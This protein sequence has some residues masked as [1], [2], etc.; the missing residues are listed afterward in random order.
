MPLKRTPICTR[1][2]S[3]VAGQ[4]GA[5]AARTLF[6]EKEISFERLGI[7][8]LDLQFKEIFRRAFQSRTIPPHLV[9]ALGVR[10]SFSQMYTTQEVLCL[11]TVQVLGHLH[12]P[13]DVSVVRQITRTPG[14]AD[15]PSGTGWLCNAWLC[16]HTQTQEQAR[17]T[18][19]AVDHIPQACQGHAA[20]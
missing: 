7:G 11:C 17:L 13:L 14:P 12:R 16:W 18:Q 2:A 15:L 20:V 5:L 4:R 8:G 9:E 6:K 3:Q 10:W 1:S 19:T